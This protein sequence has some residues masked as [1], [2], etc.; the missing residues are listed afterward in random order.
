MSSGHRKSILLVTVDC[1][2]ADHTGFMGYSRPTT[3]FLDTLASESF[4]VPTAIV[5][6]APTYY[7]LP[8][9]LAS[10]MPLALGRDVVGLAPGER[11]LATALREFGYATGA[12]SAGNPYISPRFGYEQGFDVF[13]DFLDHDF[14]EVDPASTSELAPLKAPSGDSFRGKLNG[15]IQKFARGVGLS[16]LYDELYFRYRMKI[17]P[18]PESVDAL[19]RFPSAEV[20]VDQA[21]SWLTAMGQRPFFLWLHLMDPHSPYYPRADAFREL[22]GRD[23]DPRCA[24]YMNEFWNR[25]DLRPAGFLAKRDAVVELYDAGIRSVDGQI[26]RLVDGLKQMNLWDDCVFALTADHGEEF[27][28]HG[29]RYHAPLWLSEEIVHVPL[30]IRV[31]GER[32]RRAQVSP[33]SHLHLAPTLLESAGM[34][35]PAAFRGR[36]LWTNLRN[37]I[38]WDD[39]AIIECAYACTNPF[40]RE[41]RAAPR[42]LAVRDAR[43]KLVMR[44]EAGMTEEIYDL[45]ADPE[46]MKPSGGHCI[47]EHGS[48]V[49]KTLLRAARAHLEKSASDRDSRL[50]LQARVRDLQMQVLSPR[51]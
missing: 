32:G 8:A 11:T 9:I 31:P 23:I 6:G 25:S 10:R 17:A 45:E 1:L 21:Q 16:K 39:P 46:E 49:R 2:R 22:T 47:E 40:R 5:A 27:L 51:S 26:A 20:L 44:I 37:G 48:E 14:P 19:R 24:R 28:E 12:F 41:N 33:M 30:L 4:V 3:P 35:V 38:P 34:P 42:L 43:F 29:G 36:S 15:S 50:Q 18:G 13:R 7:S